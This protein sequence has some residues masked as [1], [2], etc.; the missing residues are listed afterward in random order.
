MAKRKQQRSYISKEERRRRTEEFHIQKIL[1]GCVATSQIINWL[2]TGFALD[3]TTGVVSLIGAVIVALLICIDKR[4]T[5]IN[6]LYVFLMCT[7]FFI[8]GGVVIVNSRVYW[9]LW[10]YIP[11]I[12]AFIVAYIISYFAYRKVR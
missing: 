9:C 12:I 10:L 3:N 5:H 6:W 8:V 7:L 11:E 2:L 1:F 4:K